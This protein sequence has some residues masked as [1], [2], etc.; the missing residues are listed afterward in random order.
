MNTTLQLPRRL[1]H[2]VQIHHNVPFLSG[3]MD[4]RSVTFIFDSG[5]Q[6]L[7]L[8]A[9]HLTSPPVDT[10]KGFQGVNAKASS[11][12]TRID[13]LAFGDWQISDVE[14]MAADLAPLEELYGTH[15]D[16]IIGFRHLIAF[17]WMVDYKA[18]ELHMWKRVRDSELN[19]RQKVRTQYLYHLPCFEVR[20][21]GQKLRLL[22]D[23]GAWVLAL[24]PR[25][26][27]SIS[28]GLGH[29][30][31]DEITGGTG[32]TVATESGRLKAVEIGDIVLEEVPVMF[33]DFS[34]M[35]ARFGP[36]DG[37]IGYPLLSRVRTVVSWDRR[38]L[39]FL[40]D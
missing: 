18:S 27:E 9:H 1:V 12:Y 28:G 39:I 17:D 23:T 10:S 33:K 24:D 40:E 22:L 26:K 36:F 14:A 11:Y 30:G 32:E 5:G 6:D 34:E 15:I 13:V 38:G 2:P 31:M 37:I 35:N 8:N 21:E 4:G 20:A 3:T 16:G 25:V 29:L 19:I 7:L